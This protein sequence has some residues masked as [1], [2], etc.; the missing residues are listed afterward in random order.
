MYTRSS[1]STTALSAFKLRSAASV[2]AL[3]VGGS[4]GSRRRPRKKPRLNAP[5]G[6]ATA[7]YALPASAQLSTTGRSRAAYAT[8]PNTALAISTF[9]CCRSTPRPA[10]V[11]R[12]PQAS[13]THSPVTVIACESGSASTPM[14]KTRVSRRIAGIFAS[15]APMERRI[16]V[17]GFPSA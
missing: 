7:R 17:W 12:R 5:V 13:N 14:P 2:T 9:R 3:T 15:I 16:G 4:P 8:T 1:A 6:T 10:I 11:A